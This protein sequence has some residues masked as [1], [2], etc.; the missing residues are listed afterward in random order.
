MMAY[1]FEGYWRDVGTIQSYWQSNM[2]LI[3]RVPEFNL[4]DPNWKIFSL[5]P[6]TQPILLVIQ[7]R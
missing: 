2:N 6:C 1:K 3:E 7:A 5:I 4:F